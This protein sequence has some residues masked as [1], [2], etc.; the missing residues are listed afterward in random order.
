MTADPP[1]RF[2]C[3]E[4]SRGRHEQIFATAPAID[5]WFLLE[6]HGRW[7]PEALPV[8]ELP[9]DVRAQLQRFTREVPRSR[10]LLIRQ[11][12]VQRP[13]I[14]LFVVQSREQNPAS[15]RFE[16]SCYQDLLELTPELLLTSGQAHPDPLL[17]VCTHG[18]HDKCCAKFGFPMYQALRETAGAQVWECS[19]VGG[20]RFAANVIGMPQGAYYGHVFPSDA[21]ALADAQRDGELVLEKYRGRCCYSRAAQ[22]GEFFIRAESGLTSFDQL[23]YRD[24]EIVEPDHWRVRFESLSR[25]YTVEFRRLR[26]DLSGYF[27]CHAE[28]PQQ[29]FRFE[30]LSYVTD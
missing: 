26:E 20:D 27:T 29:V 24:S 11:S 28:K 1:A 17:L 21:G 8:T 13:G 15:V 10:L 19:H 5:V 30:L 14:Q 12:H 4:S 3:S 25:V 7:G 23:R 6:Y 2:F 16:L 18:K 9:S 22:A